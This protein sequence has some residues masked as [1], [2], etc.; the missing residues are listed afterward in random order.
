MKR[1]PSSRFSA[2]L[3][4]ATLLVSLMAVSAF[5]Q[6]QS[7]NIYGH[8]QAK[9][10]SVLP[11]VTVTLIGQ[12]APQQFITDTGGDFRFLAL[13]PGSYS[14]K[15][16]LAGFGPA[17]RSGINVSIGQS[18]EIVLTLAP[19][20]AESITVTAE[21][22]LLDTRKTG[23]GAVATRVELEQIPTGRDPW[24]VMGQAPGVLLDRVNV[25]GSESG[26]QDIVVARGASDTQKTFNVDGVNITDVGSIGSTP[27]YYDFDSFEEIQVT[28][29]GSDPRIQTPGAQLNM[30]TKRGTNDYKG[31]ARYFVADQDWQDDPAPTGEGVKWL[32]AGNYINRNSNWSADVGGPIL[33]DKLW[34]WASYARQDIKLF[35]GQPI[36]AVL[37]PDNTIL[38]DYNG[39]VNAQLIANNSA[40]YLYTYGDKLKF[41]RYA[42]AF[43]PPDAT[44]NQSGPSHMYKLEDTHIFNQN[45]YVTVLYAHVLSPFAFAP[46]QGLNQPYIDEQGVWHRSFFT[47]ETVRPQ[48]SYRADGSYFFKTGAT[49]HELKFGFGYRRAPVSSLS[50]YPATGIVGD[51]SQGLALLTRPGATNFRVKYQDYYLGDTLTMGNLTVVGGLR[52]DSQKGRNSAVNITKNSL[53]P[54][55]LSDVTVA[56]D[57]QDLEWKSISPRL[58]IT[59]T[60]GSDKRTLLR[61][62]YNRYVDQLGGNVVGAGNPYNYAHGLY[63]Y[64]DD[65][66]GDK[67]VQRGELGDVYGTYG[68]VDPDHPNSNSGLIRLDYDMEAPKTDEI[69]IGGERQLNNSFAVGLDYTYRKFTDFWWNAAE[70]TRGKGDYIGPADYDCSHNLTGTL[71][72]GRAFSVPNCVLKSSVAVGGRVITTRPDY[73]HTYSGLDLYGTKRMSN[74]WM[75]R[76]SV[77]WNDRK[78]HITS[79]KGIQ[80]PTHL[81]DPPAGGIVNN[82]FG[83]SSCDGSQAVDKSYGTHTDTYINAKW[84]YNVNALFQFPYQISVGANLTG[85]EGYPTPYYARNGARRIL[86]QDIDGTRLPTMTQFD[87]RLAKDVTFAGRFGVNFA[88]EGFNMMNKRTILQ[89]NNRIYRSISQGASGNFTG[90]LNTPVNDAVVEVQSPRIFRL[91]ARVSF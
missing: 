25:G 73:Y 52:F 5:A 62:S 13:S 74:N 90:T 42:D 66:N 9:D 35:V 88:L 43:H 68:N 1:C 40:T 36:G 63:F 76:A 45:L 49:D 56:A 61:A 38:K 3:V 22:P 87:L 16:E 37:T 60:P 59:Y 48:N 86:I 91:S 47:Y 77:S 10:G 30:V 20:A 7:G 19:T 12:G 8:T 80:D 53:I 70:K 58:G 29:G 54:D 4:A 44:V 39:K 15:A 67:L 26:Q 51:F 24:V 17:V 83:C 41:G 33:K 50:T 23:T 65:V 81:L 69:I 14:L 2:A 71:P 55:I 27:T 28:T 31:A 57:K 85:R 75:L 89:R 72:N 34:F 21:A 6:F 84:Q 78:Q 11:G 82:N 18:L 64:W 79:D 32:T 46:T